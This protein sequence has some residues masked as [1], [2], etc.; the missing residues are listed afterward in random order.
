MSDNEKKVVIVIA[1]VAAILLFYFWYSTPATTPTTV[2]TA[3][4]SP[5]APDAVSLPD[6]VSVASSVSQ[7]T[8]EDITPPVALTGTAASFV[9]GVTSPETQNAGTAL[10]VSNLPAGF[11]T[12]YN[13][14]GPVNQAWIAS[15]VATMP[16]ADITFIN[17]MV[18]QNLWGQSA[19]AAQWNAF[20]AAYGLPQ[21]GSFSS[22]TG[23][24]LKKSRRK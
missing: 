8:G 18:T 1:L 19:Q 7:Q 20:C 15:Q 24:S 9:A 17:N 3:P 16:Q 11:I 5:S 13:S 10:P 21:S 22:F 12:W 2:A 6:P 4:V 23:P 14:L